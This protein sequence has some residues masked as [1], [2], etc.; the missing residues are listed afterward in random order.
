[1]KVKR[2]LIMIL[3]NVFLGMGV[4]IFK[5]AGMGNDAFN[6]M[7]MA[8]SDCIGIIY[9][10][11]FVIFSLCLFVI[12][13]IWGRKLIGLG[14]IV[15]T[16]FLGYIVTFFNMVWEVL[17]I[18]P[19]TLLQQLITMFIG[20]LVCSFGLSMY[21]TPNMGVSP[22]D[23]LALILDEKI[24]R[25]PYFWFRIS[26]DG[27]CALICYFAG[28]LVGLGTLVAAFGIGPFVQFFDTHFTKKLLED[29]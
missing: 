16:F 5:L 28:G 2:S 14:T 17:G 29:K 25:I 10:N 12:E 27:L 3:G 26:T 4:S 8:L 20:V 18:V 1:M 24:K 13:I 11:F 9:A 23:S 15:N 7:V 6:A 19:E 22:Y 21:Q